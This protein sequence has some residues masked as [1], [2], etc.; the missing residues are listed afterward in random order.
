M[1]LSVAVFVLVAGVKPVL[2]QQLGN[3]PLA[4]EP[5][6][7]QSDSRVRFLSRGNGY[8]LFLTDTGPVL[9]IDGP[10][11]SAIRASVLDAQP[12]RIEGAN[13]LPG[14]TNYIVGSDPRRWRTGIPQFGQVRYTEIYP[15]VDLL[16]YGN[17]RQLEY[18]FVV[19][20][21]RDPSA[22]KLA[23]NG[24]QSLRLD[25]NGDLLIGTRSRPVRMQRPIAYQDVGGVRRPIA[26]RYRLMR[27]RTVGFDVGRYDT[28]A[29]LVIDPLVLV[30]SSYLGGFGWDEPNDMTLDAAGNI[31]VTGLTEGRGFPVSEGGQL[32]TSVS[33]INAFVTKIDS[34]GSSVLYSTI[35]GGSGFENSYAVAVDASGAAVVAGGTDSLDFP[36]A[37]GLQAG[38]R[39]NDD[40][41]LVKLAPDG[42]SFIYS[43][44]FGGS[45]SDYISHVALAPSGDVYLAGRTQSIDLPIRS[46]VQ[47]S[48][49]GGMSDAFAA[50]LNA[51]ASQLIY[52][53]YLGGGSEESGARMALDAAGSVFL[54]GST[55]SHDFPTANAL[56]PAFHPGPS[57][58]FYPDAFVTKLSPNGSSL[59][60]STYL[61]GSTWDGAGGV[62][63][64]G[65]GNAYVV[66]TTD[67]WE[68][69]RVGGIPR[70]NFAAYPDAYLAKFNSTGSALLF[71][72][73]LGGSRW[74]A[75]ARVALDPVG[76]VWIAGWTES[77][78]FPVK[79]AFQ[80]AFAGGWDDG[81]VAKL[82]PQGSSLL[83]ST[84]FG[85]SAHEYITGL[86][87][88]A[89]GSVI[90]TG[91][92]SSTDLPVRNAFQPSIAATPDQQG[93]QS[94]LDAY[95]AKL[96]WE[97]DL[98][99]MANAGPDLIVP[100]N[101]SCS[102]QVTLDGTQSS[103]PPGR[104]IWAYLWSGPNWMH[105]EGPT[106]T[107]PLPAMGNYTFD[108]TVYDD[109]W[110]RAMDSV[111]VT[112]AD[113]EGPHVG[114]VVA[115]PGVLWPPNRQMVPV[116]VAVGDVR[117]ACSGLVTCRI[118]SVTSNEPLA[119]GDFVITGALTVQLRAER[120]GEGPGRVYTIAVTCTDTAGN[121]TRKTVTVTVP[122][123]E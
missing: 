31:Y 68:F 110:N 81:F 43:T 76:N 116:T 61:G 14:H 118:E 100:V 102:G 123:E 109:L 92:T 21:R 89:A 96:T 32:T 75:G 48:F 49:G 71:S 7:G 122:H 45:D 93:S 70:T 73:T 98:V 16:F 29:A 59:V 80:S 44:L 39:G 86:A 69:P 121:S 107:F 115:S 62:A 36:T 120:L 91:A 72:T 87:I 27:G 24:A 56:Q 3:L 1:M 79:S 78:D 2:A 47:P 8:T 65:S 108:L 10:P 40:G 20:P 103:A 119:P 90:I 19:S 22:I 51:D 35:F 11:G 30:H 6:Q 66:G 67:S 74:D 46:A 26:V 50:K 54:V 15:G 53:T 63:V 23:I 34:S 104:F 28:N 105:A 17:Q 55:R 58:G 114:S 94:G 42:T 52:S 18:D 38:L 112:L 111:T 5:N 57:G 37:G 82:T 9:A 99:L 85:G 4:F 77:E 64:D 97:P 117:D 33:S 106:P 84:Y 101:E 113:L 41:F 88:D 60:Y 83:A 25:S 12:A 13:P 95:I